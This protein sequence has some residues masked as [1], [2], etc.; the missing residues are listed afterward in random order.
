M[1][2]GVSESSTKE[3]EKGPLTVAQGRSAPMTASTADRPAAQHKA[4]A[5]RLFTGGPMQAT[6]PSF[7]RGPHGRGRTMGRRPQHRSGLEASEV[8][9]EAVYAC[10]GISGRWVLWLLKVGCAL[11]RPS[12]ESA[13]ACCDSDQKAP[14]FRSFLSACESFVRP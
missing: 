1:V 3:S 13:G 5:G 12:R 2:S 6:V 10:G 8:T 9:I 11:R 14:G 4:T 7:P